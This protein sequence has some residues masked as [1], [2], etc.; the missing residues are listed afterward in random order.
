MSYDVFFVS[1]DLSFVSCALLCVCVCVCVWGGPPGYQLESYFLEY[2]CSGWYG[3]LWVCV[4]YFLHV[5]TLNENF[6]VL[7]SSM[8]V[9]CEGYFVDYS[10]GPI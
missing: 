1:C 4:V 6:S 10:A 7:C 9:Y 8:A 5:L 2:V 3:H